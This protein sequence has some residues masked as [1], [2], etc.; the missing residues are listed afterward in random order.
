MVNIHGRDSNHLP[1]PFP[2]SPN[3]DYI[4]NLLYGVDSLQDSIRVQDLDSAYAIRLKK[5]ELQVGCG[6]EGQGVA[7]KGQVGAVLFGL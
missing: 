6:V 5:D 1:M 3:K 4:L 7:G 2:T